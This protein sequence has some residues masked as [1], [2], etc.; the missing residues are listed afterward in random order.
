MDGGVDLFVIA[1]SLSSAVFSIPQ[2][3][4]IILVGRFV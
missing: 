2:F 4:D 1:C 3:H